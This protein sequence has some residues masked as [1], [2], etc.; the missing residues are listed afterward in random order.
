MNGTYCR[1]YAFFVAFVAAA[2]F[3]VLSAQSVSYFPQVSKPM[4]YSW[5]LAAD[6]T[7]VY[8]AGEIRRDVT[9]SADAHAFVRKFD[10][11]GVEVWTRQ[12]ENLSRANGLAANNSGLYVA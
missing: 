6:A 5:G 10:S 9:V 1:H 12:F 7:G 2:G 4:E 8:V 3:S 11:H